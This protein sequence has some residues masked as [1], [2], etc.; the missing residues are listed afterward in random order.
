MV[1]LI[2]ISIIMWEA[3]G[4]PGYFLW[5]SYWRGQFTYTV[6]DRRDNLVFC[7]LGGPFATLATLTMWFG[8]KTEESDQEAKW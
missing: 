3:S 8:R 4:V 6:K 2:V 1:F 5:R 7:A